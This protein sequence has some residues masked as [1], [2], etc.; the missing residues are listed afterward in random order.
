MLP[1][2]ATSSHREELYDAAWLSRDQ[3]P[4]HP[5]GQSDHDGALPDV[6]SRYQTAVAAM[7]GGGGRA[8]PSLLPDGR[9][10]CF[11]AAR[12]FPPEDAMGAVPAHAC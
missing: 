6:D 8:L 11:T 5:R 7:S 12:T 9:T 4:A 3:S 1:F 2:R 10:G